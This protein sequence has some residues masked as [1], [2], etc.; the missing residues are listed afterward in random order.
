MIKYKGTWEQVEKYGF[1][2]K[3]VMDE[4]VGE[5]LSIYTDT[6]EVLV[7]KIN[8]NPTTLVQM[9]LDGLIKIVGDTSGEINHTDIK[10]N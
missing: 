5:E 4:Y 2:Q 7:N 3:Y 6:R 1:R 9:T 10:T 8:F